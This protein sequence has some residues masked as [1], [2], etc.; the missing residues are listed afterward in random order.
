MQCALFYAKHKE[1]FTSPKHNLLTF[2]VKTNKAAHYSLLGSWCHNFKNFQHSCKSYAAVLLE[3]ISQTYPLCC[4]YHIP[5]I[6][7]IVLFLPF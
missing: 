5:K 1:K 6:L 2:Q 4:S 3:D 7:T